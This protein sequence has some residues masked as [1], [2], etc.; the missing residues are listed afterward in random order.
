MALAKEL[1]LDLSAHR[2]RSVGD[3]ELGEYDL[4]LGFERKH[5]VASV[6][7]AKAKVERTLT[8]PELLALLHGILRAGPAARAGRAGPVSRN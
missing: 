2:A 3:L 6:V 7:D 1:G 5:V 8:L 4:V